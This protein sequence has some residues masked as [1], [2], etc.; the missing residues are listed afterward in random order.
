MPVYATRDIILELVAGL[1]DWQKSFKETY[2]NSKP[3]SNEVDWAPGGP[4]LTW[5]PTCCQRCNVVNPCGDHHTPLLS[6]G[7]SFNPFHIAFMFFFH[8]YIRVFR[9]IIKIG[10]SCS[11]L[12]L[13]YPLRC[14]G[15]SSGRGRVPANPCL[16]NQ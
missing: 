1:V 15:V 7:L 14:H 6:H 5:L 8:R 12:G 16:I 3:F 10:N 13:K 4:L 9:A 11:T 2:L